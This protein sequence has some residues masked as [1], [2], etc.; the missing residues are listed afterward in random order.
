MPLYDWQ[1]NRTKKQVLVMRSFAEYQEP[2]T[3]EEAVKEGL[4]EDEAKE[5]DWERLIGAGIQVSKGDAWGPGK[6]NW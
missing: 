6:G 3:E 1:D 2:P 5:A 4:T